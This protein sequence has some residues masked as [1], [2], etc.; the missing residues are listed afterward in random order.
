MA[1]RRRRSSLVPRTRS[2][3]LGVHFCENLN[4]KDQKPTIWYTSTAEMGAK[5]LLDVGLNLY[6]DVIQEVGS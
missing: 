4:P 2:L 5:D 1:V 3:L 6:Y